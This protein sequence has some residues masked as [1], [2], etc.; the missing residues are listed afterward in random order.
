MVAALES[1]NESQI[2]VLEGL[3][4]VRMRPGMYIGSTSSRG[5]H[6]LVE[7]IVDNAIDEALA[8]YCRTIVVALEPDDVVRVEDDGRGIPTGLHPELKVPTPEVVFTKLHAGG[9]FG[10]GSYKVSGGLHGVGASVVNALSEWLEVTIHRDGKVHQQRYGRG[11]PQ[12][13]LQKLGDSNAHGTIVRWKSDPTIFPKTRFQI[14]IIEGRLRE[15]AYLNPGLTI[16]LKDERAPEATSRIEDLD[17]PPIEDAAGTAAEA[18]GATPSN[19]QVF[20]F[21]GGLA[22]YVQFLNA[23]QDVLTPAIV[24]RGETHGVEVEVAFQYN[25]GYGELVTSFCN[26]IRTGEGGTHEIGFKTALTRVVNEYARQKSLWKKKDNLTGN[27]LREGIMAVVHVRMQSVEFEGQTKTR[28]G[29]P[30]ARSAVEELTTLHLSAWLDEHPQHA[31]AIVEKASTALEAREAAQKAKKAVQTGKSSKTRTSLDGKLTRCSSRKAE[32]NELFIVE[33]DS[34]GGSAKQGRDR[35]H[36]AILPLKGKPLNTE[37]AT[38]AKVLANRE[39]LAV[40]QAIGAGI[41]ADFDLDEANYQR[42]IILA[43]A[44]DDG[45]HIRCLLLT[46]FHRFMKPLLHEGRV[47]IAQ[48]PLYRMERTTRG[49]TQAVYCW[50]D[51]ELQAN[52]GKSKDRRGVVIQRFKGLGEMNP[53]QLWDTT[54]NPET[55]TLVKVTVEDA[56]LAEKQVHVLM[57]GKAE[58]RKVWISQHVDFGEDDAVSSGATGTHE[59]PTQVELGERA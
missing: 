49:K 29:N 46:F 32:L 50:S 54:M 40:V 14:D 59:R 21:P 51:E 39:I 23:E 57:G 6:H 3:E 1:Y 8:G 38:L 24:Y 58:P 7:E 42:V 33:G 15:L 19:E 41:G 55:R 48:P 34:A 52:L 5:L 27:D 28:L 13:K 47:F 53:N 2:K 35:E 17:L 36:Q 30:E 12:T 16:I 43:D 4:A 22:E 11:V 37:R 10:T 26:C 9:K 20:Y 25:D 56:A 31:K 44:D 45:A 18:A